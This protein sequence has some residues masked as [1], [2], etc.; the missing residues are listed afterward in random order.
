MP[1]AGY[2]P[3]SS[4]VK[5]VPALKPTGHRDWLMFILSSFIFSLAY[6]IQ[7]Y[8]AEQTVDKNFGNN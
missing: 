6:A 4:L 7:K 8:Q 3:A 1:L 2:E 5:N